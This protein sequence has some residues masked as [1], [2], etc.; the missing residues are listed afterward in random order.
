LSGIPLVTFVFGSF[1]VLGVFAAFFAF[2]IQKTGASVAYPQQP[3]PFFKKISSVFPLDSLL[4][5]LF[6]KNF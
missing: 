4:F 5:W 2:F 6:V 3:L 1:G